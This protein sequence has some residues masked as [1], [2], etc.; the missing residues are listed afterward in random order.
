MHSCANKLIFHK[1]KKITK[2]ILRKKQILQSLHTKVYFQ[3]LISE[4]NSSGFQK[5]NQ[6]LI[7]LD[8][9]IICEIKEEPLDRSQFNHP[10]ALTGCQNCLCWYSSGIRVILAT[11]Y[12]KNCES[13]IDKNKHW[14]MNSNYIFVNLNQTLK[15]RI[16]TQS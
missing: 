14:L 12:I 3:H 5:I 10:L 8:L 7:R 4:N 1:K 9:L 2:I 11:V 13:N 16:Y 15:P 6:R